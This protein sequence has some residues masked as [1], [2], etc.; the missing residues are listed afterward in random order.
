MVN[1]NLN[2]GMGMATS[3]LI[4]EKGM[5]TSHLKGNEDGH[6]SSH[7]NCHFPSEGNGDG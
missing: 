7:K 2:K 4:S 6:L 1:S 3:H 5:I